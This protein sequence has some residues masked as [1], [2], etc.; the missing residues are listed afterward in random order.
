MPL[1]WIVAFLSGV[2]LL[3]GP[4]RA[5]GL[6]V[7]PTRVD[8]AADRG[9]QSV[10]LTNTSEQTVT[11]ETQVLV[12][13]AGATGQLANDIVVTPAV[14]TLP[15][16]Q[17]MRVR[18]G[19]L[20]PGGGE[21]ERAYRLYFTELP[22]PAPLQGA[23]VGVRLSVGIPLF[24]APD[25]ASAQPLSWSA[26][27]TAEGWRLVARNDGNVHARLAFPALQ[28][29]AGTLPMSSPYVLARSSLAFPL[30]GR[31]SPGSRVRWRDGDDERD[32]AVA[33]P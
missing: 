21:V 32:S 20:R 17:R 9:V 6:S 3:A 33:L 14:V 16:N 2:L 31:P 28:G 24:V 13:P 15:P 10:L 25:R 4:A 8:L 12:W 19:L 30:P 27:Q 29:I 11:V 22:A 23:G 26:Q 1:R 5:G 7:L 18:I